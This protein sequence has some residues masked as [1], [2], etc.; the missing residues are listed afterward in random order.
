[1]ISQLTLSIINDI[2]QSIGRYFAVVIV[3]PL[4]IIILA[5]KLIKERKETG[6]INRIRL[7]ILLIFISVFFSDFWEF[8]GYEMPFFPMEWVGVDSEEFSLDNFGLGL[9]V[10]LGLVL[11]AYLNQSKI[12]YYT[13]LYIYFGLF[14]LYLYTGTSL[15]LMPYIYISGIIGL[16]Y[17]LYTGFKLKDNG[18]LGVGVFFLIAFITVL[19]GEEG[20]IGIIDAILNLAFVSFGLFF[21]LGYF[22]PFEEKGGK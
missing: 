11:T 10:S 14:V 19:L 22:T 3:Y 5:R 21:A 16:F 6:K 8:M 1:M 13:S 12:F 9:A 15:I 20:I 4:I 18:A 7:I 2:L 17:L